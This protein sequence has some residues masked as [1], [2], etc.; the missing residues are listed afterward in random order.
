[1]RV[2]QDGIAVR[3]ENGYRMTSMRLFGVR[4]EQA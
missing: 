4:G 2:R 3:V 1:M